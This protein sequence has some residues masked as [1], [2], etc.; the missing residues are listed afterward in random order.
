LLSIAVGDDDVLNISSLLDMLEQVTDPRSPQGK[1]H[2]LRFVLAASVVATLAG[3]SNYREIGSRV[4]DLSQDLLECLGGTR[5]WFTGRYMA[6]SEPTIRRVLQGIDATQLDLAVGAW[7][8]ERARLD[9]N[10]QL[11]IALDGK[12]LRGA[13]TA[14]NEQVTLFSAMIHGKGVVI[15]QTRVPDGTN[16]ITQIPALMR[17]IPAV[18]GK[19][20]VTVDAAH[21]QR[22][23]ASYLKGER[24][25]DFIMTVKGNQP[26]LKAA[27][28]DRCRPLLERQPD[29][30]VDQRGHG[31]I[32]RWSTWTTDATGIDFP[33]AAQ[34][35]VIR[36]EEFTLE[37]I[38]ISKE[39]ALIITSLA[40]SRASAADLHTH[41]RE[42][43]GIEN[44]IHYVRDTTWR[45]DAN[46][47]WIGNGPHTLAI[48]R[49][50]AIALFR[51]NGIRAIKEATERIAADRRRALPL[52]AT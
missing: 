43:W 3:A 38:R 30:V 24:G 14:D 47:S 31:R 25:V 17:N 9:R 51:L 19:T 2:E 49:N 7:L 23:T 1:V 37:G 42:H 40:A 20:I 27:V 44:K 5:N 13:W 16:E 22:D 33:Y 52:L 26:T 36:R 10:G 39:Y 41:V 46:P 50:L 8:F 35:A 45:E 32:K 4:N 21:T 18:P 11:V 28:F 48:L 34:V 6:P 12:V 15:S 29:H